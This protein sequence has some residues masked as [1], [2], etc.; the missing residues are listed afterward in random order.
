[1]REKDNKG[2]MKMTGSQTVKHTLL[3]MYL[4]MLHKDIFYCNIDRKNKKLNR[5]KANK[6]IKQEQSEMVLVHNKLKSLMIKK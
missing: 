6:I 3:R 1:M 2:E 5:K 4:S